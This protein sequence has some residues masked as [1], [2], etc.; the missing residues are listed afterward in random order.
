MACNLV[1][2]MGLVA[3]ACYLYVGGC[4]DLSMYSLLRQDL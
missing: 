2:G 4:Y 3:R 1:F